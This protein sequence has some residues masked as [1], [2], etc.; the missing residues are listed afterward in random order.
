MVHICIPLQI[1]H[2]IE[3]VGNHQLLNHQNDTV[4]NDMYLSPSN[5]STP[6]QQAH[7]QDPILVQQKAQSGPSDVVVQHLQQQALSQSQLNNT[8]SSILSSQQNLQQETSFSN[9]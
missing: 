9:E 7:N 1:T 3:F 6:F 4:Q 5:T 2:P 8:L